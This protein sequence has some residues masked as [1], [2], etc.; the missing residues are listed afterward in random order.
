MSSRAVRKLLKE[1]QPQPLN[2][3]ASDSK[4]EDDQGEEDDVVII[5]KEQQENLFDLV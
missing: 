5:K 1:R 3:S 4:I 2:T